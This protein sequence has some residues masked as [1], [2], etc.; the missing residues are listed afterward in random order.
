MKDCYSILS[1]KRQTAERCIYSICYL[2]NKEKCINIYTT[3]W[4][5]KARKIIW[6]TGNIGAILKSSKGNSQEQV[7]KNFRMMPM[8]QKWEAANPDWNSKTCEVDILPTPRTL[9]HVFKPRTE[10]MGNKLLMSVFSPPCPTAWIGSGYILSSRIILLWPI[11]ENHEPE[12]EN[13]AASSF[14]GPES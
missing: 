10:Y 4:E 11:P 7:S 8:H 14:A 13:R 3:K 6:F 12:A 1:E 2:L 9:Y 5:H